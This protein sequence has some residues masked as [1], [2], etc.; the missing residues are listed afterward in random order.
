MDKVLDNFSV[1][2]K[3]E[4]RVVLLPTHL[5]RSAMGGFSGQN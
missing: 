4:N 5:E 2:I 3:D 1:E